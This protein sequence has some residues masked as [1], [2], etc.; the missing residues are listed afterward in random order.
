MRY[1]S[2]VHQSL[3]RGFFIITSQNKMNMTTSIG[4][5][6]AILILVGLVWITR[7]DSP[8]GAASVKVSG[9]SLT[10][11]ERKYDFGS[12]SMAAGNVE[13]EFRLKNSG[14]E[15]IVIKKIY[16]SCM[17]TEA[18]LIIGDRRK[19]PFGMPGHGSLGSIQEVVGPGE[20]AIIEVVFDPQAH[21]PAGVGPIQRVVTIE[22]DSGQPI[23]LEFRA[24]VT[25]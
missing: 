4:F 18:T 19:G 8:S 2:R 7:L 21:G 13:R 10:T 3:A 20:E 6:A 24:I 14:A 9:G 16:T 5:I 1:A 25:P 17:C 12:I 11:E 15:A 23:G 22:H